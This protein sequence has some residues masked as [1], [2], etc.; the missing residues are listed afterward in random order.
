[1]TQSGSVSHWLL[2]LKEG[3]KAAAQ[4]LWERYHLR[5]VALAREILRGSS[6]RAADE[7]DVVQNAFQSFFD[8]VARGR[9]PQLNDRHNLWQLLVVITARKA[10]TQVRKDR[11]TAPGPS[12]LTTGAAEAALMHVVGDEPTPELAAQLIEE[13]ERL[14]DKLGDDKLRRIAR[15]KLEGYHQGEIAQMLSC[16]PRTV[17][18][19]LE[20]IR[21]LWSTEYA[22]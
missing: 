4:P 18:R 19:K 7:D 3:D 2:A 17:I 20:M 11:R 8:G 9:F 13:V 16:S 15:W 6:R 12:A 14:L 5:L 1:M 21:L 10:L 22:P